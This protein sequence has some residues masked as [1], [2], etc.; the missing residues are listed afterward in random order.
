[1]KGGYIWLD[2]KKKER[3]FWGTTP[4][5]EL[6]PAGPHEVLV[7]APGFEPLLAPV[8]VNHGEQKEMEVKLERVSYG[9]L[10]I[11]SNAPEVK[12]R[13][14]EQPKG[15]WKAGTEP[16]DAQGRFNFA[17]VEGDKQYL[18]QLFNLKENKIVC[19]EGPFD[20][21][22]Q[23]LKNDVVIECGRTPA[24]WWLL[25]AAAAAGV[26]AGVVVATAS[27]SR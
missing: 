12:I 1:M 20:L 18:V 7:E 4:H 10:R 9:F 3:P 6:V 13:I 15:V 16:L 11:D 27:P 24:A 2:D 23:A 25:G 19:T 5:G 17:K 21:M 8:T 26:T 14:D 22:Q